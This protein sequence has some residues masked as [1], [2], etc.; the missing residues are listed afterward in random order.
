MVSISPK[1]AGI[2]MYTE[3]CQVLGDCDYSRRICSI[4][5]PF[6]GAAFAARSKNDAL[7]QMLLNH[8]FQNDHNDV[9]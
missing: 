7:F 4:P 5:K 2:I 1:C 8:N 3:T 6:P 9:V